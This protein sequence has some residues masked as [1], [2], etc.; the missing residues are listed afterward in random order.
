M[1][2]AM[3]LVAFSGIAN[4]D[5]TYFCKVTGVG[6]HT[7]GVYAVKL[8]AINGAFDKYFQVAGADPKVGIAAFLT[9]LTNG[10]QVRV[11]MANTTFS[12]MTSYY[13]LDTPNP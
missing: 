9:A 2:A 12:G 8:V 3:L 11:T 1:L 5:T 10:T 4:A 6:M 7:S 13:A